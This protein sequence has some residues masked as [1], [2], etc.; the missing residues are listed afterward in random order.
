MNKVKV[1]LNKDIELSL[2]L[3]ASGFCLECTKGIDRS[4]GIAF[5]LVRRG[6]RDAEMC[7]EAATVAPAVRLLSGNTELIATSSHLSQTFSA[8]RTDVSRRSNVDFCHRLATAFIAQD[9]LDHATISFQR[10]KLDAH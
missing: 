10:A 7:S 6:Q 2:R 1:L 3:S 4:H 9:G 8:P 5:L